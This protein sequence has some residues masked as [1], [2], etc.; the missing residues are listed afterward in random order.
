MQSSIEI[1]DRKRANL[2]PFFF[3]K[4]ISSI[5][6]QSCKTGQNK[7]S[8]L[9]KHTSRVIEGHVMSHQGWQNF[10]GV[11]PS[12]ECMRKKRKTRAEGSTRCCSLRVARCALLVARS[13]MR[14]MWWRIRTVSKPKPK[15]DYI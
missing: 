15:S 10:K 5:R 1:G 4:M 14:R 11:A 3:F 9:H 8:R 12:G 6:F 13:E 2:F 7:V